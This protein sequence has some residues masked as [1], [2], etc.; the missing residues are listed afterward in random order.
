MLGIL[1]FAAVL[2]Y[3][4]FA[5]FHILSK[6]G[7]SINSVP[8]SSIS[9]YSPIGADYNEPIQLLS[10]NNS[11]SEITY[12]D[13][14]FYVTIEN[15]VTGDKRTL[16][17]K[18]KRSLCWNAEDVATKFALRERDEFHNTNNDTRS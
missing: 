2:T 12:K 10:S 3:G 15:S 16:S 18:N 14:L 1:I 9:T 13:G 5:L 17:H 7:D 4:T 6:V 11:A 8:S